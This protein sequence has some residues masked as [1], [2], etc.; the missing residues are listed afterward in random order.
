MRR[1]VALFVLAL[2]AAGT[3]GALSGG[4]ALASGTQAVTRSAFAKELVDLETAPAACYLGKQYSIGFVAGR[5]TDTASM[6]SVTNW[7]NLR[8]E[9]LAL[10]SYTHEHDPKAFSASNR[11][12]ATTE[13]LAAWQS[14]GAGA[15]T[16]TP[17]AA[18]ASLPTALSTALVDQELASLVVLKSTGAALATTPANLEAFYAAHQADYDTTCV[19]IALV[20]V[21]SNAAFQAGVAAGASVADLAKNYSAD[22]SSAQGGAIGCFPPSSN[23]RRYV[24]GLTLNQYGPAQSITIYGTPY[25]LYFAP[26]KRTANPYAAVANQVLTDVNNYNA[27]AASGLKQSI[28]L[29]QGVQVDP[30][31][32]YYA[33]T[34]SGFAINAP[35]APLA[36]DT[37]NAGAGLRPAS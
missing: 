32:G 9:G 17:A 6:S 31:L 37:P 18:L 23:L 27:G 20:P 33:R 15:C 30:A 7:A 25:Y 5:G 35:Q 36:T 34:T 24:L 10:I 1:L 26:T 16:T 11:A 29:S 28:I 4:H 2:L 14:V 21:S 3:V 13:L 22:P 8:L 12:T 19:S